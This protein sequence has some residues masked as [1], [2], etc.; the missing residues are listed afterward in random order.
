M[1]HG[2]ASWTTGLYGRETEL[3]QANK[4][5]RELKASGYE[6]D[7]RSARRCNSIAASCV[8][9]AIELTFAVLGE[10]SSCA[11]PAHVLISILSLYYV[12]R[13]TSIRI[14]ALRF[15]SSRCSGGQPGHSTLQVVLSTRSRVKSASWPLSARRITTKSKPLLLD[16]PGVERTGLL[17]IV[18]LKPHDDNELLALRYPLQ[19][20]GADDMPGDGRALLAQRA[21]R[22]G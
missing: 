16:E 17:A 13:S 14:I 15:R 18:E 11:R 6:I 21:L 1:V 9:A 19:R 3:G 7:W 22:I 20:V 2:T 5:A 12:R 10:A 4:L 8:Q